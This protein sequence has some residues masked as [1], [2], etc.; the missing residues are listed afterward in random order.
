MNKLQSGRGNLIRRTEEM[1]KLGIKTQ[2]KINAALLEK[3][4]ADV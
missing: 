2:K 3:S 4:C 1:K